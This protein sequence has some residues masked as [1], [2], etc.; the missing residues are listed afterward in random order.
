MEI[1]FSRPIL[2]TPNI[3]EYNNETIKIK[4]ESTTTDLFEKFTERNITRWYTKELSAFSMKIQIDFEDPISI[5]PTFVRLK[6][7]ID[8]LGLR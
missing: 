3:S 5:S 2:V 8:F 6:I 4:V 7:L 1:K